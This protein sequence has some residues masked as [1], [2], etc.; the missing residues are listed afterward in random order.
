MKKPETPDIERLFNQ[1]VKEPESVNKDYGSGFVK[2]D[3]PVSGKRFL[4]QVKE[5]KKREKKVRKKG[6]MPDSM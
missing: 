2:F 1:Y 4:I 6:F 5:Y 3:D